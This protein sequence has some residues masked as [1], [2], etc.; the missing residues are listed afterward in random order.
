MRKKEKK[1]KYIY[2]P[3]PSRR[4]GSSLGIDLIPFKTCTYDCIYC[5]LGKTKVKTTV[6]KE[7]VPKEDVLE[8]VERKLREGCDLNYI[9][10]AGSGE[11]TLHINLGKIITAIKKM[12]KTPV[13][14]L[15]NGSLLYLK[16]VRDAI[17]DADLVIPSLDAGSEELF[18][19]VNRSAPSIRFAKMTEG[20]I[21]FSKI[22]KGNLW[23]EVMLVKGFTDNNEEIRKIASIIRQ[24]NP[25]KVQL[26]T[27]VRPP[28]EEF[29]KPLSINE[30][31]R[32]SE[33]FETEVEIIGTVEK[34]V[35]TSLNYSQEELENKIIALTK[36][37]PV[38]IEDISNA[39]SIKIV[40]V[41]KVVTNLLNNKIVK[42]Q[43]N[44]K[45]IYY[46]AESKK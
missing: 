20:L 10:F 36:R 9:T 44:N 40:E 13:A 27:V 18:F 26:N 19:K 39:F 2:G 43:I 16:E 4:L 35:E 33:Y 15:T 14:V 41:V 30:L 23:L 21:E 6:R 3:V 32:F 5:Q 8:E 25:Q 37:R 22:F 34:I 29:A 42:E 12:T 1:Y 24:I 31:K 45:K 28:A 38:T 46:S 7:Y 17:L 11:P